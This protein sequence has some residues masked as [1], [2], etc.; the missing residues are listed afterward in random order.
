MLIVCRLVRKQLRLK[1]IAAVM[2]QSV[3]RGYLIRRRSKARLQRQ[4]EYMKYEEER[5]NRQR[6]IWKQE[7]ELHLLKHLPVK[8]FLTF[9]RMKQHHSAKILQRFWRGIV[10]HRLADESTNQ[11]TLATKVMLQQGKKKLSADEEIAL[12]A[13]KLSKDVLKLISAI[14][15]SFKNDDKKDSGEE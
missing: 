6:R 8:D 15:S 2:I 9:D 4:R 14:K 13:K 11:E 7:R 1:N 3:A 5:I 12:E 10:N